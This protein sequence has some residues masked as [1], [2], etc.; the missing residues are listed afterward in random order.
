MRARARSW[1]QMGQM[2]HS[3]VTLAVK[4]MLSVISRRTAFPY[5][6]VPAATRISNAQTPQLR[7][8][9]APFTAS[10]SVRR[11]LQVLRLS[12]TC[13]CHHCPK[14]RSSKAGKLTLHQLV[15]GMSPAGEAC[16]DCHRQTPILCSFMRL[17]MQGSPSAS[18]SA[19]LPSSPR[20]TVGAGRAQCSDPG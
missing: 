9:P 5:T 19:L 3:Q 4:V 20:A 13:H 15:P 10:N 2:G 16:Y 17:A 7:W 6:Q 11:S 8:S 14:G 18:P 12:P 1:D